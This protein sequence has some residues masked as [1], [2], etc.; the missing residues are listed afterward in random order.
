[1]LEKRESASKPDRGIVA[2]ETRGFNQDRA[3]VIVL[4]RR[5]LAPKRHGSCRRISHTPYPLPISTAWAKYFYCAALWPWCFR[6][7]PQRRQ[8]LTP[9]SLTFTYQSGSATLPAAQTVSVKASSGTPT[10]TTGISPSAAAAPWLTVTPSSGTLPATLNVLVNPTSL[11][12][13]IYNTASVAVTVAG[14]AAPVN[15]AVTLTVTAPPAHL[16][17]NWATLSFAAPGTTGAQSVVLSTD[18]LPISFTATSGAKWLLLNTPTSGTPA[19]AVTGVVASPANPV[20][21]TVSIDPPALAALVPQTAPY[22]AKITV[23]ASGPPWRSSRR[24]LQ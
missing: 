16:T 24:I 1:M 4:R 19:S 12:L 22:V 3:R 18:G 2:I 10:F 15:I 13:G 23:V 17:L 6:H 20:T 5:F 9:T 8:P 14:V 11:P 7:K 21:L